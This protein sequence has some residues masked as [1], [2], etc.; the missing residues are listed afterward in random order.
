MAGSSC[1]L[2]GYKQGG[3]PAHSGPSVPHARDPEQRERN[4][5][6]YMWTHA[7]QAMHGHQ[8]GFRVS[9]VTFTALSEPAAGHT[10]QQGSCACITLCILERFSQA[11]GYLKWLPAG[12][13]RPVHRLLGV[14]YPPCSISRFDHVKYLLADPTRDGEAEAPGCRLASRK[15]SYNISSLSICLSLLLIQSIKMKCIRLLLKLKF[16][17]KV[18]ASP[19]VLQM[20]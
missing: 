17:K 2:A 7:K 13:W 6:V 18:A 11:P 9:P 1:P 19:F 12:L 4:L 10:F 15:L 14:R 3:S 16:L 8:V 5:G 20:F